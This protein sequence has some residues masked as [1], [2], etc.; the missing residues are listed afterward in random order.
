LPRKVINVKPKLEY[1]SIL[2]GSG[3]LDAA[4]DPKLDSD[5]SIHLFRLMLTARRL[6]ER[7]INMQ[8]Q[9]RI[10]TYGPCR[11]QE[12]ATVGSGVQIT[13]RSGVT[14]SASISG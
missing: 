12:A 2:D 13:A 3:K 14:G 6:D 10:G 5:R 8:R 7:C 11:G 4:L 9:G 1:L